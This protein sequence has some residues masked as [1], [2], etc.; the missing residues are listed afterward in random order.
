M[1]L[2]F[3][4]DGLLALINDAY[5]I[6]IAKAVRSELS[7]VVGFFI[8]INTLLFHEFEFENNVVW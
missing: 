4:L 7:I 8:L 6:K 2:P 1:I 5:T 3:A